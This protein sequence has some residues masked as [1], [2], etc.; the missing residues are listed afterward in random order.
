MPSTSSIERTTKPF[1]RAALLFCLLLLPLI[2]HAQTPQ[3]SPPATGTQDPDVLRVF[4]ELVQT[5]VM[6]FDKEGRFV[7]GLKPGDFELR[8]DGKPRPVEFFERIVTGSKD[9]ELQLAAARG[10]SGRPGSSK[11]TGPAPL[12]RGRPIFFYVDDYHLD[13]TGITTSRKLITRFIENEMGQNDEAAIASASGQIG[14]LQQLTDSKAV[15]RAALERLK[16]RNQTGQDLEQPKMTEYQALLITQYDRDVF[17]YFIMETMKLY[18]GISHDSAA[19]M[20]ETRARVLIQQGAAVTTNTLSGLEGLVKAANK[21][22]GRKVIFFLSGGFFIDAR[23]SDSYYRLQ[24]ITNA[25][26]R[27]GV[28]I[29]SMD[30]RGLVASLRDASEGGGFNP[31][32]IRANAGELIASQDGMN[33]LAADTGGKAVFNTNNLQPGLARALKDTETYYLLAWKPEAGQQSTKFR[34]IEVKVVGRPDLLVQVRRGFFD[35]EPENPKQA[36]NQKNAK[37]KSADEAPPSPEAQLRK[38][39]LGVYPE[40]NVPVSLNLSYLVSPTRGAMLSTAFQVPKEFLTFEPVDGKMV[41]VVTIVGTVFNDKGSPG[42]SF[43]NRLTITAPS[44]EAIRDGKD[45]TYGYPVYVGPGLYQVRVGVLDEKSGRSG[46]AHSWI[47]IPTLASGELALSS[48]LMGVRTQPAMNASATSDGLHAV[49]MSVDHYFPSDGFLR[50]LVI[51]YNAALTAEGQPDVAIQV[52]IVR[53]EQ[54][55]LTT[56]LKRVGSEGLPD[57]TR[58]PYA[59]EITL[60][61][62]QSG[63]YILK[64]TAVDRVTKKSSSQQTRFEV[65]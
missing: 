1:A 16:I 42:A 62:L 40:R 15:L 34:R 17:E 5:D 52:Q 22:P 25:A 35:R 53:D 7:T 2:A 6:V 61:G 11:A 28:V 50:F 57:L 56:A 10:G 4:T 30:A 23:N 55:V 29:Y 13:L 32:I 51:I 43:Q 38:V 19:S 49:E 58:I 12:D 39:M 27:N 59:A 60:N 45:L 37:P 54:P 48:V 21:L 36:K 31:I 8:I 9:E 65:N 18:P 63:R 41:A 3:A 33:A 14:F 46:T 64:V 47:Q 44:A 20:V 26:A 24:R